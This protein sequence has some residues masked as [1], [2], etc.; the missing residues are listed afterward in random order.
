VR[1]GH[2]RHGPRRRVD[3]GTGRV[4]AHTRPCNSASRPRHQRHTRGAPRQMAPGAARIQADAQAHSVVAPTRGATTALRSRSAAEDQLCPNLRCFRWETCADIA[5][6]GPGASGICACVC[7]LFSADTLRSWPPVRAPRFCR[8]CFLLTITPPVA[9]LGR[10]ATFRFACEYE[11][12][13]PGVRGWGMR[14]AARCRIAAC[15]DGPTVRVRLAR[16]V[17]AQGSPVPRGDFGDQALTWYFSVGVAGF[18]PT[19]SSSRMRFGC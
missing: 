1:P 10:G 4:T 17:A 13:I 3:H 14:R 18:E 11:A 19:T 5:R 16:C 2:R 6:T 7:S 8:L 12:R 9:D 15:A